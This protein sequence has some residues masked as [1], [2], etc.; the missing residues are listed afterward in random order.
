MFVVAKELVGIPGLPVTTKGI[1]EALIRFSGQHPELVRR[2][3]GT[4]AFEYHIDCLPAEVQKFL[5]DRQIRKLLNDASEPAIAERLAGK[6]IVIR[7]EL[8]NL[9]QFPA[10]VSREV[11]ALTDKQRLI[12]GARCLLCEEV[13]K[14]REHAEMGRNAA[15]AVIADGSRNGSLPVRVANAAMLANAR[16]GKRLG[17]SRSSLQEWYSIYLL[18][19]CDTEKRLVMLAPRHHKETQP[20][21][22]S[23]L[24]MFL[25]H[26]RDPNGPSMAY[27]YRKFAKEWDAIYHDQPAMLAAKPS[28]DVVRRV[29]NKLPKRER[30]R[31]RV[32][33]AGARALE[34]Y[35]RRDWS[36]M[37][38]NG[39]WICDGK[40]LN[41]KVRHPVS[42]T[43]FTPELTLIIDGRS[44]F[45]VGFS[46]SYSE[47]QRGV[48]EAYRYAI[49]KYGKPLFV[50][51]DNGP[52]Q[53]NKTFDADITGI[54]PRAGITHM[55]GIPGNPQARGIIE[56]LNAV[57]PYRLAQRFATYNGRGADKD[58]L[59]L[60]SRLIDS[61]D[62]ADK[63]S[64]PLDKRQRAA[65]NLVPEWDYVIS[66]IQE[67]I[68]DYNNHHEHSA[69]PLFQGKHL[70]PAVYREAVLAAEG[71][72]IEYLTEIEL[73]EMFMPEEIRTV[74]R[75]YVELRTNFYFSDALSDF[76][77]EKV[78]VA[79]D[80]RR[81]DEVIIRKMNGAFIC[82]AVW[83]GNTRA[84]IPVNEM[85]RAQEER[86]QRAHKR[87][88]KKAREIDA[89]A[90]PALEHKPDF[91]LGFGLQPVLPKEDGK[92][93]LYLFASERERDLKKNGTHHR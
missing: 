48:S 88:D 25:V 23:W 36:L 76:D 41:M 52:G 84:A 31:G 61:A 42:R 60:L 24:L 1:R 55:T 56:R 20:E 82:T 44:R 21:D 57:I 93:K 30:M 50:Y 9:Q 72:E 8:A 71:D 12:I 51:T 92:D 54:F 68:D 3:A 75:G 32:S 81:A 59:K 67:E 66:A 22:I 49:E 28:Y 79:Y 34:T 46:L 62:N 87:L 91:N 63:Q 10:L 33:G 89:Q 15:I 39:C 70:S 37:P 85:E 38:V 40:S 2:R 18:T 45:V 78:R 27:C 6:N 53:K 11:Q 43:P 65:L 7:E 80:T 74:E 35:S 19:A 16:K 83:N 14:L 26:W 29:M 90:V 86:R 47:N 64:K 4:K 5:R 73:R 13:D 17:V 77:G 69:L 58:G